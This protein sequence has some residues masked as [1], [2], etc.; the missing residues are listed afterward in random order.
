[1]RWKHTDLFPIFSRNNEFLFNWRK[2]SILNFAIFHSFAI[3]IEEAI[4]GLF[5]Q[6]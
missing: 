6:L 5:I 4:E 2:V 1:M 3:D